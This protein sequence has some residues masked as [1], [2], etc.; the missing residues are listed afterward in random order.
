MDRPFWME[1]YANCVQ[2]KAEGCPEFLEEL[3]STAIEALASDDPAWIRKG[4]HAL[5]VVGERS[6]VSLIQKF[7]Q[8]PNQLI[9]KDA[10]TCRFELDRRHD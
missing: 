3:R 1:F 8:H 2:D 7:E 6:D 5:A 10:K 9:A 4:L